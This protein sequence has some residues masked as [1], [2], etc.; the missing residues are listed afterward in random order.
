MALMGTALGMS[1]DAM[2]DAL[3]VDGIG[4]E[5]SLE[6]L[7]AGI[8]RSKRLGR[9]LKHNSSGVFQKLKGNSRVT[10]MKS[11]KQDSTISELGVATASCSS[12]GPS[13]EM[14]AQDVGGATFPVGGATSWACV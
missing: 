6:T 12:T 11:I 5:N 1:K 3:Q 13:V 10:K 9:Q 4:S 14:A 2:Q 7:R 8:K